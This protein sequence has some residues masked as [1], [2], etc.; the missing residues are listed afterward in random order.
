MSSSPGY[1]EE[2]YAAH[3]AF[4]FQMPSQQSQQNNSVLWDGYW[5]PGMVYAGAV[6]SLPMQ[7]SWYPETLLPMA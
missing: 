2:T 4:D 3:P 5:D 7:N 6:Q 1:E